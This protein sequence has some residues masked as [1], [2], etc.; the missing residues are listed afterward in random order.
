MER[1]MV[2]GA[3]WKPDGIPGRP[4]SEQHEMVGAVGQLAQQRAPLAPKDGGYA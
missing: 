4:D 3:E 2:C 1:V